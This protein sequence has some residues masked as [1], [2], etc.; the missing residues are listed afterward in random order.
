[1]LLMGILGVGGRIMRWFPLPII[2][3]M[4]AGSILGYVTRLVA[5]TVEDVGV[6]GARSDAIC[7]EDSLVSPVC[8]Q[9]V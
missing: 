6:A 5:A 8:L 4:F 3:G 9:W 2:M 1:M 7:S